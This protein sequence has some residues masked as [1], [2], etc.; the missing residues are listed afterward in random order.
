MMVTWD[1]KYVFKFCL[2]AAFL[3]AFAVLFLPFFAEVF[4][5]A[6]FAFAMEPKLGRLLHYRHLR[7]RTSVALILIGSF[8]LLAVLLLEEW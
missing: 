8:F 6:I 3:I 1:R 5:A 2:S 7:W 4:L